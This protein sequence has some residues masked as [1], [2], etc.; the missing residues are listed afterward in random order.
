MRWERVSAETS[1]GEVVIM[2]HRDI[3]DLHQITRRM[4]PMTANSGIKKFQGHFSLWGWD[5]F[6]VGNLTGVGRLKGRPRYS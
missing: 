4:I 1:C 6:F 3:R 5:R 2:A